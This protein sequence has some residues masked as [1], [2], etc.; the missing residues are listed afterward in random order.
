MLPFVKSHDPAMR[1]FERRDRL[2]VAGVER[3]V[4]LSSADAQS[5]LGQIDSIKFGRITNE[6]GVA[7][8]YD[9]RD[10]G[11]H[12]LIDILVRPPLLGDERLERSA[13]I[14]APGIQPH[15]HEVVSLNLKVFRTTRVAVRAQRGNIGAPG[16]LSEFAPRGFGV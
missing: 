16:S 1:Q 7:V 10:N 8:R 2:R 6:R 12:Q 3:G 5:K 9:V 13:E 14:R 11:L 15:G 4:D